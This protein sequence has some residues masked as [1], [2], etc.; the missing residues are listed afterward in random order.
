[1]AIFSYKTKVTLTV[2]GSV[3]V[4]VTSGALAGQTEEYDETRVYIEINATDGDAGLHGLVDGDAWKETTLKGSKLLNTKAFGSLREQ[5]ITELFFE[6]DEPPCDELSEAVIEGDADEDDI[7]TVEDV[8][9]RFPDGTYM[10]KGKSIEPGDK[11]K[12]ETELTH[13][14]PY[15]PDIVNDGAVSLP[16]NVFDGSTNVDPTDAVIG[17]AEGD[18]LGVCDL[19]DGFEAADVL[20]YEVTVEP[21]EDNDG[22]ADSGPK[23]IFTVQVPVGQYSVQVSPEYL[24]TYEILGVFFFKFEVGAVEDRDIDGESTKGN[25]TFS[26]GVFEIPDA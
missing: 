14:L 5:G 21:D 15:A 24:S 26:E 12:S 10:F 1:M 25:Q 3:F 4:F 6:S 11:L 19:P 22:N 23:R 7:V 9:E 8:L 2:A 20:F 16:G 13:D 18:D 17:W